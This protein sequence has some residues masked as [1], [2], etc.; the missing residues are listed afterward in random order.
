MRISTH[1]HASYRQHLVRERQWAGH[2]YGS[3]RA[4]MRT[5]L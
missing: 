3:F 2:T 1:K 4:R 5:P